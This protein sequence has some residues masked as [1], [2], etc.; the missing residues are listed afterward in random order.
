MDPETEYNLKF[1]DY[2]DK[3]QNDKFIFEITKLCGYGEFLFIYKK[4]SLL[5][6]YKMVSIQFECKDIKELYFINNSTNEKIRIPITNEITIWEFIFSKNNGTNQAIKPIYPISCKIVY[7]IYFDD[8][9]THG[10]IPCVQKMDLV[11]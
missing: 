5:D 3:I 4:Q 6:L 1:K 9:H 7:R 11:T 2:C 8:G 10:N